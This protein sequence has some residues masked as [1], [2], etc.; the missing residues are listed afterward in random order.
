MVVPDKKPPDVKPIY[1]FEA[2]SKKIAKILAKLADNSC[3][4][5]TFRQTIYKKR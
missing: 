5:Q 4:H 3:I 1:A 2:I